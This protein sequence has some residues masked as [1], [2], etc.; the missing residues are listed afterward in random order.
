MCWHHDVIDGS[1]ST[2]SLEFSIAGSDVEAFFPVQV[3]FKSESFMCPIDI[4]GVTS[5]EAT[6]DIAFGD[7]HTEDFF[8]IDYGHGLPSTPQK[9]NVDVDKV[10]RK[11]DSF[12]SMSKG[13][14]EERSKSTMENGNSVGNGTESS[15]GGIDVFE[16][17]F[18]MTFPTS[19]N[20]VFDSG[21]EVQGARSILWWDG[22]FRLIFHG[23]ISG[24]SEE[25]GRGW[26]E[27]GR[28]CVS[29]RVTVWIEWWCW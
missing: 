17:S 19:F 23:C 10:H 24:E 7:L 13:G 1:N 4:M 15:V 8:E 3:M 12:L 27:S 9:E 29:T 11:F 14:S 6:A 20:V 26:D 18:Q 21:S 2:G 16:A 5:T 22:V 25:E 28:R